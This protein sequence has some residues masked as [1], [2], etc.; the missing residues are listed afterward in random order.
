MGLNKMKAST[1]MLGNMEVDELK[2]IIGNVKTLFEYRAE[3]LF[4]R[5]DSD[6]SN[7]LDIDEIKIHFKEDMGAEYSDA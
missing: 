7:D 4:K 2:E 5:L 3:K 1:V 6:N